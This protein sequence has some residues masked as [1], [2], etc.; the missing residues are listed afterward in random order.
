M[1]DEFN[2][3]KRE[4][5]LSGEKFCDELFIKLK[6]I[7]K[8]PGFDFFS[9]IKNYYE[10]YQFEFSRLIFTRENLNQL[11]ILNGNFFLKLIFLLDFNLLNF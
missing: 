2:F 4:K 6:K 9:K 8:F 1:H 7:L 11:L 3:F 10:K 5:M